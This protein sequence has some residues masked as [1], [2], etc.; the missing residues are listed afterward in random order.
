MATAIGEIGDAGGTADTIA[1]PGAALA[2][3]NSSLDAGGALKYGP[4]VVSGGASPGTV[5]LTPWSCP[6]WRPRWST[7]NPVL[8]RVER[9]REQVDI[10]NDAYFAQDAAGL[11]IK[12][13][14]A[15]GIPVPNKAIRKLTITP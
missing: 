6:S 15:A 11:R 2:A 1:L 13:R 4:G 10:C 9:R 14:C 7:T 5:G 8:L 3:E 12:A